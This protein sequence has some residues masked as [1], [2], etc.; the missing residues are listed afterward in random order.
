MIA[1]NIFKQYKGLRPELY[2]L[3]WGR[4]VTN[5]G[6]LIWPML[7]LILKNKLGY[8]AGEAA[9]LILLVGIFMLPATLL[10][11]RMADR[12]NKKT[13]IVCCDLVTVA[14][15]L[16]CGFLPNGRFMVP[17][18]AISSIF[19]Q[20]EWPSYDAL[21]ANLSTPEERER[22]YSLN[23][24]GGNL[25]LVLAPTLGGLLFENHLNLAFI[26]SG[27]ATLSSTVL[28]F[29]FVKDISVSKGEG[30]FYEEEKKISTR[31]LFKNAPALVMFVV[32]MGIVYAIYDM[33]VSFMIP[34][35]M[36]NNFGEK[37]ALY[38]GTLTSVN[39]LGVIIGTPVCTAALSKIRDCH[40]L[41]MGAFFETLGFTL[42]AFSGKH[43]IMCYLSVLIITFGEVLSSLG[44]QP[45]ITRRVP[46]SHRGR[47]SAVTR[48]NEMLLSGVCLLVAG[49]GADI[50]PINYIW[51]FFI[52]F[53]ILNV[54]LFFA[55]R[56]ADRK[57]FSQLY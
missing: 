56:A 31:E 26:I 5:M 19:A 9:N 52:G 4:V 57:Q 20:V 40:K 30:G 3:F 18:L 15:Y 23:Y 14:G 46:A 24:L 11:G 8:T 13:L 36:D 43:M 25:G 34:L 12:F 38:L 7:T 28:I 45:Y 37:G 55:M 17:L 49:H 32:C 21:V 2:I 48:V 42:L 35:T 51:V 27:F 39:A 10:G 16:L 53:G 22:A 1:L 41:H 29:F 33:A 47:M 50:M 54:L 6:A 44:R